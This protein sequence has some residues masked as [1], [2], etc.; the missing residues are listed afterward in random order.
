MKINNGQ[1]LGLPSTLQIQNLIE[2]TAT[3]RKHVKEFL[4]KYDTD[5]MIIFFAN[6]NIYEAKK[7]YFDSSS[8]QFTDLDEALKNLYPNIGL[9][10]LGLEDEDR[11]FYLGRITETLTECKNTKRVVNIESLKEII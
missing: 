4:E 9:Q 8:E 5:N 7:G 6:N 2:Q 10:I 1:A 3:Y 11:V